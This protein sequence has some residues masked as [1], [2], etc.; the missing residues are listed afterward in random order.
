[1]IALVWGLF[2]LVSVA[3]QIVSFEVLERRH[4]W[5]TPAH[6]RS[7]AASIGYALFSGLVLGNLAT[8]LIYEVVFCV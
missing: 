1:M 8:I 6:N 5:D 2:A 7:V 4:Y 3:V